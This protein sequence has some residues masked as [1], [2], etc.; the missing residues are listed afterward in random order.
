MWVRVSPSADFTNLYSSR[1][2]DERRNRTLE[3][4]QRN[5]LQGEHNAH[6]YAYMYSF[7]NSSFTFL[8]SCIIIQNAFTTQRKLHDAYDAVC[9]CCEHKS[10]FVDTVCTSTT[11]PLLPRRRLIRFGRPQWPR[12]PCLTEFGHPAC[13][14]AERARHAR[15]VNEC[16]TLR[17]STVVRK[18]RAFTY[19]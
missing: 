19:M 10:V 2:D 11:A 9:R 7:I 14:A 18:T 12:P 16:Y 17:I 3:G 8:G 15:F 13:T 6:V 4:Q 5:R 1:H